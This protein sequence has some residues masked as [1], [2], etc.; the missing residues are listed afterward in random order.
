MQYRFFLLFII[1]MTMG[2]LSSCS[3]KILGDQQSGNEMLKNKQSWESEY[4]KLAA[5]PSC[6][7]GNYFN[8][9]VINPDLK[10]DYIWSEE[11]VSVPLE[12]KAYYKGILIYD[13]PDNRWGTYILHGFSK[14]KKFYLLLITG[15]QAGSLT[16]D[17]HLFIN[18]QEKKFS[19]SLGQTRGVQ[20]VE[21]HWVIIHFTTGNIRSIV[22]DYWVMYNLDTSEILQ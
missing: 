2:V 4:T 17:V 13:A 14:D 6:T 15:Y 22:K 7:I 8:G 16:G 11:S 21:N 3:D 10:I 18:G 19:D 5:S 1:L 12:L 20:E 9:P